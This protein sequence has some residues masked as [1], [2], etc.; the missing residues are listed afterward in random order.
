MDYNFNCQVYR[1]SAEGDFFHTKC[2]HSQ[3]QYIVVHQT[4]L[5]ANTT[6]GLRASQSKP[7]LRYYTESSGC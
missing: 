4:L 7:S 1:I 5:L 3:L 2:H 6:A